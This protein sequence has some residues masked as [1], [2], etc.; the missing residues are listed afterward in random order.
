MLFV[1]LRPA[2][3]PFS[4]MQGQEKLENKVKI[5]IQARK[6]YKVSE[7]A[8]MREYLD[9]EKNSA[10]AK[11]VVD[12]LTQVLVNDPEE[13]MTGERLL[14]EAEEL[15]KIT[16]RKE[17]ALRTSTLAPTE[18]GARL[19]QPPC[20]DM[21]QRPNGTGV[22]SGAQLKYV[23]KKCLGYAWVD[24]G[25]RENSWSRFAFPCTCCECQ[26]GG[27]RFRFWLLPNCEPK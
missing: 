8:N 17:L 9:R 24:P 12:I 5:A 14:A 7:D 11:K 3:V 16:A 15:L 21:A 13:R 23:G 27:S 10:T 2:F 19:P 20:L 22:C 18:Y 4:E 1:K 6:A 25:C 26:T